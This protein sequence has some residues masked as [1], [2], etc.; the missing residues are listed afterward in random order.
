[1]VT[2]SDFNFATNETVTLELPFSEHMEELRQRIFHIFW[3]VLL[4]TSIAFFE[5]KILVKILE[6][7]VSNVKFFQLS[8]G[9]YFVSTVKI[10]FYTGLLF[11]S[12]F[13]IGQ[14]I[15]FLLPGLTPKGLKMGASKQSKITKIIKN[16]SS[17]RT[18]DQDLQK[19][20]VWKGPNL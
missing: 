17:K 7:P 4:L 18:H 9:E 8:P 14:I 10:S 6:L 20:P 19:D 16:P 5:V 11:S 3:I 15:L 12:P 2:N 1:M 13:A